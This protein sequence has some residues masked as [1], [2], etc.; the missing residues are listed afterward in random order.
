[1]KISALLPIFLL[2]A[3][4]GVA[5][6]QAPAKPTTGLQLYSLRS[7]T[8][9]RGV[10][11]VLDRVKEFGI[12]ELELAGTGNLTPEQFKAEVDKRG[13]KA[14]SSHFPYARYKNDLE[15][16][17]KDA[18]ALG[19]K[20]AVCAWIDH[21]DAF[22]EAECRDAIAVF[23]K[24]G[25]ALAKEG[26]TFFYHAHGYE[27]EKQGEGTLLDLL[28]TET[29]SEYVSYQMDVLWIVFPGQDPVKLLEKYGSRWK[30]M[31]LKDLKKGVATGS[32]SGKTELT[33]DV[34]LGT[35]QTDWPAVIAAAKKAGV[36]HYFIEDE[37]P[38]SM[39]QIPLSVAFM[40]TQ[41]F[42]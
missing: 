18:K 1:M 39:E 26:I 30:L 13:L 32:L 3:L 6:A 7:Q 15:G 8:A 27:F 10:P 14:V 22:D 23:N 34:T 40:K 2:A 17:V 37:S 38:T 16:V 36:Q 24:A 9:L 35:G 21:K 20:F 4:C 25:E 33:N 28:I 31:H 5:H 12:T 41:G 11:W 29:K 42:E 19:I